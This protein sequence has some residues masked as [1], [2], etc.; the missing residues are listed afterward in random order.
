MENI[1]VSKEGQV[2]VVSPTMKRLDG[3]IAPSFKQAMQDLIQSGEKRLVLDLAGVEFMDS[4]GLGAMVSVLKALGG[5]G[6]LA[7]C[8][9][10]G[11]VLSLF[12][13]TRMDKVFTIADS[14]ED[15]VSRASA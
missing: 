9:V 2:A 11:G 4:S 13:L 8:N 15:A 1:T 5:A 12:K 7:V 10:R 6:A 3:T 14:R